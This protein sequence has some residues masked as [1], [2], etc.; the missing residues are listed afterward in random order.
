MKTVYLKS[1][2]YGPSMGFLKGVVED[3][4]RFRPECCVANIEGGGLNVQHNIQIFPKNSPCRWSISAWKSSSKE[5][6]DNQLIKAMS[7]ISEQIKE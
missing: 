4:E 1:S 2:G 7:A 5:E 6:F 3:D